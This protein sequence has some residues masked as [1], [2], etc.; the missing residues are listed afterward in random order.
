[1]LGQQPEVVLA[2]RVLL[3]EQEEVP[4]AA[5]RVAGWAL[6][7]EDFSATA[8]RGQ[9]LFAAP[10][11]LSATRLKELSAM[12]ASVVHAVSHEP[13]RLQMELPETVM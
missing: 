12:G 5:I 3:L 13:M 2:T 11:E 9:Q 6:E 8:P 7:Q 1:L 10:A 4:L